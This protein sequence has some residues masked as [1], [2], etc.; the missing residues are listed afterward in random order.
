[1]GGVEN[2]TYIVPKT[3]IIVEEIIHKR[4]RI[5]LL[6]ISLKDMGRFSNLVWVESK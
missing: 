5:I 1:M 3:I 4:A 6:I 2:V